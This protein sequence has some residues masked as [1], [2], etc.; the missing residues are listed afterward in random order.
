MLSFDCFPINVKKFRDVQIVHHIERLLKDI[1]TVQ[2][3]QEVMYKN[4]TIFAL[5]II[6]CI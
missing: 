6:A 5:I 1:L 4:T 3:Q 2:S